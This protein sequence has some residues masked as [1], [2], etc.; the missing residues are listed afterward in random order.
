MKYTFSWGI[1]IPPPLP[2][3]LNKHKSNQNSRPQLIK[4]HNYAATKIIMQV[5][6]TSEQSHHDPVPSSDRLIGLLDPLSFRAAPNIGKGNYTEGEDTIVCVQG[7][8]TCSVSSLYLQICHHFRT[9]YDGR[10]KK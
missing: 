4:V 6:A 10:V 8:H 2:L 9:H 5:E 3:Y 1:Y 7:I